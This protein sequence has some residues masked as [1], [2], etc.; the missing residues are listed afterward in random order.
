MGDKM[1]LEEFIRN[2]QCGGIID[3]DGF[4]ELVDEKGITIGIIYPSAVTQ[5]F[6]NADH[7]VWYNK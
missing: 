4:G 7:V 5:L 6:E 1:S 3:Y 2:C